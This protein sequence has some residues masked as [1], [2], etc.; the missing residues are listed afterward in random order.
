MASPPPS[1]LSFQTAILSAYGSSAPVSFPVNGEGIAVVSSKHLSMRF[2]FDESSLYVEKN[3]YDDSNESSPSLTVIQQ[4]DVSPDQSLVWKLGPGKY[5]VYGLPKSKSS[6]TPLLSST[7]TMQAPLLSKVKVEHDPDVKST[8]L[9]GS[10][11]SVKLE[12]EPTSYV[13]LSSD[14]SD[15][16]TVTERP[17][18]HNLSSPSSKSYATHSLQT[19]AHSLE[20]INLNE[21]PCPSPSAK[22]LTAASILPKLKKLATLHGKKNVLKKLDYDTIT[23]IKVDYL[24]PKFDGDVVYE[25][26]A[27]SLHT[28]HTTARTMHGMDKRY[29]GHVWT[30]TMTTNISN[31]L[32]LSFRFSICV[33]HL[34]CRNKEC[35]YLKRAHR[36]SPL[37][38]T[39]FEGCTWRPFMVEE[40]PP[41]NSTL[42]CKVCKEPPTCVNSCSAK[43]YYVHGGPN[44]TRA[45]IHLGH[46][47]HPVKVGDY[48]DTKSKINTVIEEQIQRTPSATK[49][50]VVLEASKEL[51]GEFL[52]RSEDERPKTLSLEDLVPVL[53]RF[54][55]MGSP[56][57]RNKVVTFRYL[58]RY[59]V[60]DSITKLRGLSN[61]A[62]VQ[63]N[64]FPGQG[65]DSD[66]VF[67]FKM[68]EMG[69]GSG[70]DLVKRMQTGGDLENC[71]IMFDHVKRVKHWTTMGCHVY[72]STYCRVMTI[73]CCDMQ[74]EDTDAQIV[75]WKNLNAVMERHDIP[76]PQ[77]M[78]F[79]ADSA[80]ANWNA[81]RIIYGNGNPKDPMVDR[82]RT[83]YFHWSQSF[84]KHNKQ[85]IAEEFREQHKR[86]CMQYRDST[87]MAEA[88][89]RYLAIR[90]WWLSSGAASETSLRH[91]D[92]WLAF[93]HFRY[94]QWGGCMQF[95][96]TY[97]PSLSL[98]KAVLSNIFN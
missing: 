63:K 14:S 59:G 11:T 40:S 69:P 27:A 61:W 73:A 47:K 66:K 91:L 30:R 4:P 32:G 81:L 57:I 94:R 77:F 56:S 43:I 26:P 38:D 93:W 80:Q 67:I 45:C 50:A 6:G 46:H 18:I 5:D 9:Y 24:P 35:E 64:M 98:S 13:A 85:Y 86:L 76:N 65:E 33:G 20:S 10:S 15:T 36:T 44:V 28:S 62:F 16:E 34:E 55:D 74:S 97:S 60:M 12:S 39:E 89:M 25:F 53:D 68:S 70:V 3:I 78:G 75:F 52:L 21:S 42:V 48:R 92:L 58:R 87:T 79:M 51:L 19:A 31:P 1:D 29:D 82:E 84:E 41:K 90:A 72:D 54:K 88:D 49:S 96:S 95:V 2:H 37:N 7:S 83:C 8:P 17:P 71:W 22:S 23:T